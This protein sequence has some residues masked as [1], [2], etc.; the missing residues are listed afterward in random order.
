MQ[1][2]SLKIFS[3]LGG[4]ALL[5]VIFAFA[6]VTAAAALLACVL[7]GLATVSVVERLMRPSSYALTMVEISWLWFLGTLLFTTVVANMQ[8]AYLDMALQ[9][10]LF[11]M[12]TL[13]S[14]WLFALPTLVRDTYTLAGAVRAFD[15]FGILVSATV[16]LPLVAGVGEAQSGDRGR[17]FGPFG[18]PAPFVVA[19][20]A[21][22]AFVA[23][24]WPLLAF[25]LAALLV[26]VGLGASLTLMAAFGAHF[27]LPWRGRKR[28]SRSWT[29]R[30]LLGVLFA[31]VLA[32]VVV[33]LAPRFMARLTDPMLVSMT[34]ATRF[35]SFNVASEI[36][37]QHPLLGVGLNGFTAVAE[38]MGAESFF[39]G[40]FH[41]NY[42]VNAANQILQTLTDG[43]VVGLLAFAAF[44][45]FAYQRLSWAA[46]HGPVDQVAFRAYQIWFVGILVGNQTAVWLLPY[47][48]ISMCVFVILG[49]ALAA[50][51]ITDRLPSGA[52]STVSA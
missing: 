36:I 30:I 13:W 27:L 15:I 9:G 24:R 16:F 28:S 32:A 44:C 21:C 2:F 38:Y 52:S 19:L 22:R 4:C 33:A 51:R 5:L 7:G 31:P 12:L 43:G 41:E 29:N 1:P 35:G 18:D 46:N 49:L 6:K 3:L 50:G 39:V 26:T 23:A 11:L 34:V 10:R 14:V 17:V 40:L 42:I 37:S 8:L 47:S 45:V 20:F 25:H 48:P